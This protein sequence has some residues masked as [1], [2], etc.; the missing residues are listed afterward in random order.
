VGEIEVHRKKGGFQDRV[1]KGRKKTAKKKIRK[2]EASAQKRHHSSFL[3]IIGIYFLRKRN[4]LKEG[5][6]GT[7]RKNQLRG[8]KKKR[9]S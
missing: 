4:D 2:K 8:K 7:S 1:G 6:K 9:H 3:R 5:G